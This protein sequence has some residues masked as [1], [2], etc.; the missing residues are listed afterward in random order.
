MGKLYSNLRDV[1]A[2]APDNIPNRDK[3]Q[4]ANWNVDAIECCIWKCRE[5]WSDLFSAFLVITV[6][7]YR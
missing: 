4:S 5:S 1:K 3:E 6:S 7:E 2:E